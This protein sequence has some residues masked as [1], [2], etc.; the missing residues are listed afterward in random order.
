M[1]SAELASSSP[2][3]SA[4]WRDHFSLNSCLRL[5]LSDR[6]IERREL[7]WIKRFFSARGKEQARRRLEEILA[8]GRCDPA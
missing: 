8:V 7:V 6:Q 5:S 4:R 3:A 2:A 1:D